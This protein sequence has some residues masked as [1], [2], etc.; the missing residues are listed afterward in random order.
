[1]AGV[2]KMVLALENELL[3]RTLHADHPTPHVDWSSGHVALLRDP[4]PWKRN[5]R[6]RRAAVSSFGMSGTNAH[7]ILE[8]APEGPP[9][10]RRLL[11]EEPG[12]LP[13]LLSARSDG[14]LAAQAA[15]L[16]AHLSGNPGLDFVDVA[17][18]LATTRASFA[19][20]AVVVA[21]DRDALMDTLQGLADGNAT[22]RAVSGRAETEGRVTFVFP[23]QGA[24]WA[25][26]ARKLVAASPVFA[27]RLAECQ[28]ALAPFVEWS[29]M[30]ALEDAAMLEKIDILQP[31]LFAMMVSLAAVWQAHGVEPEAVIGHSQ[32]EVAAAHIA[33]ALSLSDASRVVAFRARALRRLSGQGAMAVVELPDRDLAAF[34]APHGGRLSIAAINGPASTVVSGDPDA[35]TG[36]LEDL[37]A[38]QVLARRVKSDVAGHCAQIDPLEAEILRELTGIVPQRTRIPLYSTVTGELVD[39]RELDAAYWFRNARETVRFGPTTRKLI[40]DGQRFFVEVSPHPV[41]TQAL[42]QAGEAERAPLAVVGTLKRDDGGRDRLLLSLAQLH[43]QGLSVD[44]RAFFAPLGGR[45]IPLPTYAFQRQSF[46]LSAG[47]PLT[48]ATSMGLTAPEHALLSASSVFADGSAALLSAR[49]SLATHPWLYERKWSGVALAS[50]GV[51][52]DLALSAA[53]EIGL[54]MI[55]EIALEA[56]VVLPDRGATHLQVSV[57]PVADDGS[58]SLAIAS[59]F[60]GAGPKAP[61][62]R[63]AVGTIGKSALD[64]TE[65]LR[66]WPPEGA[67]PIDA[68]ELYDALSDR[69]IDAVG[70]F[71]VVRAAY[72]SGTEWFA[73]LELPESAAPSATRFQLHPALL[74]GAFHARLSEAD[75]PLRPSRWRGVQIAAEGAVALRVRLSMDAESASLLLADATGAPLGA[76]EAITLTKAERAA[77]GTGSPRLDALFRLDWVPVPQPESGAKRYGVLGED[78]PLDGGIPAGCW[79]DLAALQAAMDGGTAVPTTVILPC[80]GAAADVPAVAFDEATRVLQVVQRW[81]ED[82]RFSDSELVLLTRGAVSAGER[83][84]DDLARAPLWGLLRTAQYEQRDAGLRI[85]DLDPGEGSST[86]WLDALRSEEPQLAVRG[87]ALF[88]PRLVRAEMDIVD[89]VTFSP[90]GTVLITGGTATMAGFWARHLV[91]RCGVRHVVLASRTG[92]DGAPREELESLGASVRVVACDAADREPLRQLLSEIPAPHPLVCVVHLP[93]DFDDAPIEAQSAEGMRSVLAPALGAL[94]LHEL[95]R[96]TKLDAFVVFSSLAGLIGS[97]GKANYAAASTFLDALAHHRRSAGLPATTLNW[98]YWAEEEAMAAGLEAADAGRRAR[99]GILPLTVAEALASFDAAISRSEAQLVPARI[100]PRILRS[101]ADV[102][103]AVLRGLAKRSG[104]RVEGASTLRAR[105]ALLEG[106]ERERAIVDAVKGAVVAIMGGTAASLEP[107][108]S[109]TDLGLDSLMAVELRKYI[110]ALTG[111][112]IP[113]AAIFDHRTPLGLA[114]YLLPRLESEPIAAPV[115]EKKTT[116]ENP[117]LAMVAKAANAG[118]IVLAWQ[119]IDFA[120][121]L[122]PAASSFPEPVKARVHR[123]AAGRGDVQLIGLPSQVPPHGPGQWLSLANALRGRHDIA[124]VSYPGYAP[125]EP[126]CTSLQEFLE[127]LGAAVLEYAGNRPYALMGYSGGGN[128]AH[129]LVEW[130]ERSGAAP[131]AGL[132]LLETHVRTEGER[133]IDAATGLPNW[134]AYFS[135]P[136]G[137]SLG[138]RVM[139]DGTVLGGLGEPACDE[140]LSAMARYIGFLVDDWVPASVRTP[141][142][143]V[144]CTE[145]WPIPGTSFDLPPCVRWHETQDEIKVPGN[146]FTFMAEFADPTGAAISNWIAET[147]SRRGPP[148]ESRR[149]LPVEG[150]RADQPQGETP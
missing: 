12:A 108:Q 46:W 78:L 69:G 125:G 103:P 92:G 107:E 59:R 133:A 64:V 128:I 6:P 80:Q 148:P 38:A 14:A 85:V 132:V 120:A 76:V 96:G 144:C 110:A 42:G 90:E 39:G 25:G 30:D 130:L 65:D 51:L 18:S 40:E 77:R 87:G 13:F 89:P 63:H 36:L 52:I 124:V 16:R 112:R 113:A 100:D 102:M 123:I 97:R 143:A 147:A 70:T 60:D 48:D 28:V 19:H 117:L 11:I 127:C 37:Q 45:P 105:L 35:M 122:R 66:S 57:G 83:A 2:I 126:L 50:E 24:Q 93:G 53:R 33:G 88:A 146:H 67:V 29:L 5:G 58:R 43:V 62:T 101:P 75:P 47:A 138:G 95:T 7:V 137:Q 139:P 3:P 8:E 118:A 44:W 129:A 22:L 55:V 142:V 61:W 131:P 4:A 68:S 71:R 150:K 136:K 140:E 99:G 20:R 34:L 116:A 94:N 15:R 86:A 41:L 115:V 10:P 121:G 56:P 84:V 49:V 111:L 98:G 149:R 23:G 106:D 74:D 9:G 31:A 72:R 104:R 134:R 135:L 73:Q 54:D 17:H 79:T 1:V 114:R 27:S 82:K 26:M 119:M 21:A 141:T 91:T 32:G 109:L 81:L 145:G